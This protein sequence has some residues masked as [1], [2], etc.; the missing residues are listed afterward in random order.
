MKQPEPAPSL[1]G[2]GIQ[3]SGDSLRYGTSQLRRHLGSAPLVST[4]HRNG[5]TMQDV[6]RWGLLPEENS[7]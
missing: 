3:A 5:G 7:A 1:I 2:P 4:E 6:L